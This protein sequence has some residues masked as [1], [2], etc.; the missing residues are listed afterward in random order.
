[1]TLI[2]RGVDHRPLAQEVLSMKGVRLVTA[3]L[4]RK[5]ALSSAFAGCEAVAHC[6]GINRAEGNQT[7]EAVHVRGTENV[8]WAAE[9]AGGWRLALISRRPGR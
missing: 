6:A 8:V 4:D 5:A 2:A 1:M 7:F 3:G 9:E